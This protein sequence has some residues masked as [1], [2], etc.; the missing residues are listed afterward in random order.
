MANVFEKLI[1]FCLLLFF[2]IL[3]HGPLK[4]VVSFQK[5]VGCDKKDINNLDVCIFYNFKIIRKIVKI[6]ILQFT[7]H[8]LLFYGFV[9]NS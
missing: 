9:T 2:L 4:S 6:D 3:A 5:G 1:K 8:S 7:L